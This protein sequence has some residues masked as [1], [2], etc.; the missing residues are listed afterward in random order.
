M[1]VDIKIGGKVRTLE[2]NNYAKEALGRVYGVDPMD[3]AEK[4]SKEWAESLLTVACDVIYCGLIG[5]YR[6]NRQ[7]VDFTLGEVSRWVAE[8]EESEIAKALN[9]WGS[10]ESVRK[11]LRIEETEEPKKKSPGKKLK[12]SL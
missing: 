1:I 9:A 2:F 10:T 7:T 5:H 12:T 6:V 4:M 8:G 11:I 3:S